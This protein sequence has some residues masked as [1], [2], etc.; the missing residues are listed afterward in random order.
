VPPEG[1][2]NGFAVPPGI[3]DAVLPNP[4][5]SL[6]PS[7]VPDEGNQWINMSYGPLSLFNMS[8]SSGSTGYGVLLGNYSI[9]TG[10]PAVNHGTLAGAPNHDIFGT[11]RPQGAG[12]DIGAVELVQPGLLGGTPPPIDPLA[13]GGP[14]AGG[15]L[16]LFQVVAPQLPVVTPAQPLTPAQTRPAVIR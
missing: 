7:A 10:S 15:L 5:F 13:L 6:L 12:I 1:G 8:V 3:A 2:G 4:L 9:K 16:G 11:R 14:S